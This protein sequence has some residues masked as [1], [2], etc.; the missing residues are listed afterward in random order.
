MTTARNT[1]STTTTGLSTSSAAAARPARSSTPRSGEA[2]CIHNA[3][4]SLDVS[5]EIDHPVTTARNGRKNSTC[6]RIPNAHIATGARNTA[7][8]AIA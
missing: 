3:V 1:V 5:V 2:T 8:T 6:S 7:A 4:P